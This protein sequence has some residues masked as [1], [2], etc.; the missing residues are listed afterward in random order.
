MIDLYAA[1]RHMG[2][3]NLY[4][5]VR[6]PQQVLAWEFQTYFMSLEDAQQK[7]HPI[8][9]DDPLPEREEIEP[10]TATPRGTR[11]A[12]RASDLVYKQRTEDQQLGHR[13]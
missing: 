10:L 1:S 11:R 4:K 8:I 13:P 5:L 6:T 3:W 7:Y 12:F 9:I 2:Y